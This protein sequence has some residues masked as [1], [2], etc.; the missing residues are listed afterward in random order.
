[1]RRTVL[2]CLLVLQ[3]GIAGAAA[4]APTLGPVHRVTGDEPFCQ[5]RPLLAPLRSGGFA[6]AWNDFTWP[7]QVV[8]L[9]LADGTGRLLDAGTVIANRQL[10]ALGTDAE[11]I[12]AAIWR[13]GTGSGYRMQRLSSSG[14][15]LG[16]EAALP[17]SG[18]RQQLAAAVAPDGRVAVVWPSGESVKG[19]WFSAAGAPL[20]AEFEIDRAPAPLHWPAGVAATIDA[21]GHLVAAWVRQETPGDQAP[22]SVWFR[23]FDF[24]GRPAGPAVVAAGPGVVRTPAVAATRDGTLVVAWEH[25]EAHWSSPGVWFRLF[26]ASGVP[27]GDPARAGE[28]GEAGLSPVLASDGGDRVALAWDRSSREDGALL[29]LTAA[30]PEGPAV[31]LHPEGVENDSNFEAPVVTFLAGG[32]LAAAWNTWYYSSILPTGCENAG[33]YERVV[34][35]SPAVQPPRAIGPEVPLSGPAPRRGLPPEIAA[36]PAL[37]GGGWLAVWESGCGTLSSQAFSIQAF[38]IQAGS[39]ANQPLGPATEIVKGTCPAPRLEL[40]LARLPGGGFVLAWS[41]TQLTRIRVLRLG[42][43]GKPAAPVFEAGSPGARRP[44]LA[45]SAGGFLLAWIEPGAGAVLAQPFRQDGSAAAPAVTVADSSVERALDLAALPTGGFVAAWNG[46]PTQVLAR[47]LD[48][49][50]A[51]AGPVL[52]VSTDDLVQGSPH[53]APSGDGFAVAWSAWAP[54]FAGSSIARLR[55]FAPGGQPLGEVIEAEALQNFGYDDGRFL[56]VEDLSSSPEGVLWLLLRKRKDFSLLV[57]LTGLAVLDG[58]PLGPQVDIDSATE[59]AGATAVNT[60]ADGCG[61]IVGWSAFDDS[62]FQARARRFE[63]G[64]PERPGLSLGGGRFR[65]EVVWRTPDGGSGLGQARPLADDTGAFWFFW[66]DNLE[67]M[68]KVLDGRDWNSAFWVFYATLTDVAFDLTVTDLDTGLKKVYSKPQGRMESRAD[69]DAFP[70][71]GPPP[72]AASSRWQASPA[73]ASA[74]G[75][76]ATDTALCLAGSRFRASVRFVHPADGVERD[77]VAVPLTSE[78]GAFWFFAPENLEL[79]LKIVD[80]RNLN[81]RFWVFYGGLSDVEYEITVTDTETGAEQVYTNPRGRIESRADV[82]AFP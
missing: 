11:G 27:L 62:R 33:I 53:V 2:S 29:L 52:P 42:A 49:S 38:S 3:L 30:G 18:N 71:P 1:M 82:E 13:V 81:G 37:P 73:Q 4:A 47:R 15:P 51:P 46:S 41:D 40:S 20:G 21:A 32:R 57:E 68:V 50:G 78:S 60:A 56:T 69:T 48:P 36:S 65:A 59:I 24:R 63:G 75:C 14:H 79:M 26:D 58:Q 66:P 76:A 16:E 64:C 35:P 54:P 25:W 9:R 61:W 34:D 19:H 77:A 43:D 7:S 5:N 6:V 28:E 12:L 31:S 55:R 72:P 45:E 8:R 80:G 44:R 10:A 70:Q 22:T 39:A 23:R 74:T 67:L 17:I